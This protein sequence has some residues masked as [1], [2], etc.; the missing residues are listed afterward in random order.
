MCARRRED[1]PTLS[2][3]RETSTR[4]GPREQITTFMRANRRLGQCQKA[5]GRGRAVADVLSSG[6]HGLAILTPLRPHI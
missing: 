2:S 6:L 3:L 4:P 1:K 5:E